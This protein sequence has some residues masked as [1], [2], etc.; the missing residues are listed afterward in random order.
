MPNL[1]YSSPTGNPNQY[2]IN[3]DAAAN[4]AGFTDVTNINLGASPIVLTIPAAAPAAVYNAILTVRNSTT[5]CVSN[6]YPITITVNARPVPTISGPTLACEDYTGNVFS[7]EA[8]MSGYTWALTG[9]AGSILTG[10]G[11]NSITVRWNNTGNRTCYRKLFR[12]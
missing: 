6:P 8:G 11:T 7:T 12:C 10:V 5:G 9:G 2:N 3:Y 1:P 4:S